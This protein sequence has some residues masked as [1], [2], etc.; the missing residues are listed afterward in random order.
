VGSVQDHLSATRCGDGLSRAPFRHPA[1]RLPVAPRCP[2]RCLRGDARG[3][4]VHR[5]GGAGAAVAATAA[6]LACLVPAQALT[7]YVAP[8]AACCRVATAPPAHVA[9]RTPRPARSYPSTYMS[10]PYSCGTCN[11]GNY[12]PGELRG[13]RPGPDGHAGGERGASWG[14]YTP[15]TLG[16]VVRPRRKSAEG[17]DARS[18][19]PVP[20]RASHATHRMRAQRPR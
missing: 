5:R 3:M 18:C 12:C 1:R 11:L 10:S 16:K 14:V 8:A 13:V 2:W 9:V 7:W 6:L 19:A 17:R 15:P 4:G 20:P